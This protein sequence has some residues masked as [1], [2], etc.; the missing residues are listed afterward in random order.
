MQHLRNLSLIILLLMA[1]LGLQAQNGNAVVSEIKLYDMGNGTGIL[2]VRISGN[3][4]P[5]YVR[6]GYKA[7]GDCIWRGTS[8]GG[9]GTA[10]RV[11]ILAPTPGNGNGNSNGNQEVILTGLV[12]LAPTTGTGPDFVTIDLSIESA[13]GDRVFYHWGSYLQ[14]SKP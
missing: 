11:P 5:Q 4:A 1:T 6:G 7:T 9:I 8:S 14:T 2:A 12:P 13:S 10:T 3:L